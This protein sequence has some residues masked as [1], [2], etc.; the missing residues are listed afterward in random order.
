MAKFLEVLDYHSHEPE[1]IMINLDAITYIRLESSIGRKDFYKVR[2]ADEL[3][4][5]VTQADLNRI[6]AAVNLPT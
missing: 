5:Y 4:I 2:M 6:L 3:D 1:R